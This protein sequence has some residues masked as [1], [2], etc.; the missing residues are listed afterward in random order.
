MIK[1]LLLLLLWVVL[2]IVVCVAL[3]QVIS[4]WWIFLWTVATFILGLK[5]LRG[6]TAN[7]MP[8][9]QQMQTTGQ[10][11]G[12]PK[13]QSNLARALAGFLLLVPGILS[14]I[15]ALLMFIPAVQTALR[16]VLMKTMLKRQEAMM[17]NM[18]KGMG[19][20]GAGQSDMMSDLMRRMNEMNGQAG[21]GTN[22]YHRPTVIDG[23]A[24]RVEPELKR[25]KPANDE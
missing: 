23:E 17:Q 16:G 8:Q 14:D 13:V 22:P 24:R 15:L 10:M 18:M 19:M 9:L 5:I 11:S 21:A 1:P 3:A 6:S 20:G 25:I 12:E 2:E 4:G 7:I